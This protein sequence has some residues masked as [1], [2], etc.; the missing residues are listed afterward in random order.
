MLAKGYDSAQKM[1][2]LWDVYCRHR[3]EDLLK[4]IKEEYANIIV[5]FVPANLT[6]IC[7]PLDKVKLANLRSERMA[8]AFEAWRVLPD[9]GQEKFRVDSSLANSKYWFYEDIATALTYMQTVEK[10]KIS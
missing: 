6:E 9:R 7:Q 4:M 10:K 8:K 3:D 5:L 2:V 1:I